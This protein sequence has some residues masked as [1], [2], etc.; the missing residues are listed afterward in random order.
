M[1]IL[2]LF[3][4]LGRF[5]FFGALTESLKTVVIMF[6]FD[7]ASCHYGKEMQKCHYQS[8]QY[9]FCTETRQLL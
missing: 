3:A 7:L 4:K 1:I 8:N 5:K 9:T 2:V 6:W